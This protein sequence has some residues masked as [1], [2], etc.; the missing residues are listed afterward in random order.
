MRIPAETVAVRRAV[1]LTLALGG[2]AGLGACSSMV[3]SLGGMVGLSLSR[4]P[5]WQSLVISAAPDANRNSPTAVDIVFIREKALAE[6][7]V[8]MPS[9]RWFAT[10]R[11][12]LRAS[13]QG[14]SVIS[15]EVVPR[16]SLRL[17]DSAWSNYKALT[18]FLFAD[19]PTPG[20]HR[21][22]LQL[23]NS[24]YVIEL[25]ADGFKATDASKS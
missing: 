9:S 11:D 22:R 7:M 20:E 13:P 19:Y 8:S 2:A 12:L 5:D 10:R 15:V 25:G 4:F 6:A 23:D 14:L 21:E 18:C 3:A 16:Q 1:C 24:G 17:T